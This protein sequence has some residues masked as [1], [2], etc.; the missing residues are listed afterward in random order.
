MTRYVLVLILLWCLILINGNQQFH[1]SITAAELGA[2]EGTA[3]ISA[4]DVRERL[5][6]CSY[7]DNFFHHVSLSKSA[8]SRGRIDD[9]TQNRL[10]ALRCP[11]RVWL[12]SL[13]RETQVITNRHQKMVNVVTAV[14]LS[15]AVFQTLT[16]VGSSTLPELAA[17]TRETRELLH[18]IHRNSCTATHCIRD[19]QALVSR[20]LHSHCDW[21]QSLS[22]AEEITRQC[23]RAFHQQSVHVADHYVDLEQPG[24][25]YSTAIAP[26]V[27]DGVVVTWRGYVFSLTGF[28]DEMRYF[29][30]GLSEAGV[31]VRVVPVSDDIAKMSKAIQFFPSAT[32]LM[33]L[34]SDESSGTMAGTAVCGPGQASESC[35]IVAKTEARRIEVAHALHAVDYDDVGSYTVLRVAWETLHP[36]GWLTRPLQPEMNADEIWATSLYNINLLVQGA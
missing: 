23:H 4:A 12:Q 18:D 6:R 16:E 34:V 9:A 24:F 27:A 15:N 35:N 20:K 8:A 19:I 21:K 11:W 26:S 33:R 10:D 13:A 1:F 28:G 36:E 2:N 7:L 5:Q 14:R 22:P 31:T 3:F 30:L 25:K 17:L 32:Q 29:V